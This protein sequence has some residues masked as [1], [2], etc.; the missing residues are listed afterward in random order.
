MKNTAS[1][2]LISILLTMALLASASSCSSKKKE[3][4]NIKADDPWYEFESF[5]ISY[6]YSDE[7]YEYV[8]FSTVGAMN[9]EVYVLVDAERKYEGNIRDLSDKEIME[10]FE[11]AV[12]KFS[13]HGEYLGK[14]DY[15]SVNGDGTYRFLQKAWVTDN[16]LNTLEVILDLETADL[17]SYLYN[18]EELTLPEVNNYY[19]SPVYIA[20]MYTVEG[21]TVY[22]LYFNSWNETVAVVR[23]DGTFYEMY[24]SELAINGGIVEGVMNLIPGTQGT[25]IIPVYLSNY[26]IVFVSLDIAS[27]ELKELT[28]LYG[29]TGTWIERASGKYV[30]RDYKGFSFVDDMT[31][32][33]THICDYSDIDASLTDIA[34]S[35]LLYISDNADEILLGCPIYDYVGDSS[36]RYGYKIM[37]LSRADANPNAGKTVLTLSTG[38]DFTP[39]ESDFNAVHLFNKQNDSFFIKYVF[40]Y[41]ETG[42]EADVD[43]DILLVENPSADASDINR[44]VDLAPLLGIDDATWKE[45][46]FSNAIDAA[47]TGDSL[48]RIPVNISA[49]GIITASSN[50]PDGQ[51]GFTFDQY[52][53]FVDEVCNGTDPM[54]STSGFEMDKTEYFTKLFLNMSDM[55]ISDGHIDISGD[56]FRE[57]MLFV[58]EHGNDGITEDNITGHSGAAAEVV[59]AIEG[60]NAR[61]EGTYGAIYGNLYSFDEYID[62]YEEFGDGIGIYGLPSFDGR[63]PQTVS[64]EFVCVLSD[65]EYPKECAEF[66]KLLL[67]YDVQITMTYSNPINRD[68]MRYIAGNRLD[69]Y[70]KE[71]AESPYFSSRSQLPSEVV[72][73]YMDILSC[74][75]GGANVGTAIEDIL[76]EEASSYFSGGRSLDDVVPVLQKRI[77]TVLDESK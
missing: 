77:Q 66:V 70:N 61:L 21:Y 68:A 22:V 73:E 65:T 11:Q 40:P 56:E 27:G 8:N 34:D 54:S 14:T 69:F 7:D 60:H 10:H 44:Y 5:D 53:N 59:S 57:L 41:D 2:K 76:R 26:D 43:P 12:L 52:V 63:G 50:M 6:L 74:S 33:L 19:N 58:D 35:E 1:K 4:E 20:D 18:G 32:D 39:S 51:K 46:Y 38:P 30:G 9:G 49:S 24:S 48:Y 47:R 75:Y 31:G 29:N 64:N 62:C 72:D 25:V 45:Q 15:S 13:Y 23:P 37:H 17:I 28:G 71:V 67:S 55:F 42:K 36:S 16:E 3:Y